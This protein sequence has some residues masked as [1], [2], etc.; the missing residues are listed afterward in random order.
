MHC[1]GMCTQCVTVPTVRLCTVYCAHLPVTMQIRASAH[2][3]RLMQA[4]VRRHVVSCKLPSDGKHAR[5]HA[6]MHASGKRQHTPHCTQAPELRAFW[7]RERMPNGLKDS[8]PHVMIPEIAPPPGLD[9]GT[10]AG[11]CP[12]W[13]AGAADGAADDFLSPGNAGPLVSCAIECGSQMVAASASFHVKT[14]QCANRKKQEPLQGI[15]TPARWSHTRLVVCDAWT[16][17]F[18]YAS[19]SCP[20]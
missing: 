19:A 9:A 11:C 3:C 5:R 16:L 18:P 4:L 6:G 8:M 13:Q 10:A 7:P 20:L 14:S 17:L 2:T 12:D 15:S 1:A